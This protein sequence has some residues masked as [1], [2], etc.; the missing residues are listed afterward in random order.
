N[1]ATPNTAS[2]TNLT[3]S[4]VSYSA[5]GTYNVT[6]QVTNAK[7]CFSSISKPAF[8]TVKD[9]PVVNFTASPGTDFCG[10]PHTV[11]FN[12]AVTGSAPGPYS[13]SWDLDGATSTATSPSHT[14]T[15]PAPKAYTV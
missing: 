9:K 11:T 14:Y 5:P 12:P 6:V 3:T 8:I 13:Y 7:G 4:N 1:N 10:E 2:G 15:G